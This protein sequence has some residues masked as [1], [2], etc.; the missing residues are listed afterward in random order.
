MFDFTGCASKQI[1]MSGAAHCLSF[2]AQLFRCDNELSWQRAGKSLLAVFP[3]LAHNPFMAG[4]K[5]RCLLVAGAIVISF[6]ADASAQLSTPGISLDRE[7][8]RLSK[9]EQEKRK[10]VDEAY[11]SAIS[12]LPDKKKP[13]DPWGN[14][15]SPG[16]NS[17]R[18]R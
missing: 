4:V 1:L 9:E 7:R 10:A 3:R 6:G 8:P 5:I 17:S 13:A 12:K 11:Q 18:P 2:A 16:T 15:R 14:M